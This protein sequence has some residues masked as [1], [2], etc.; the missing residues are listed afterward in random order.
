[1]CLRIAVLL[2]CFLLLPSLAISGPYDPK[3]QWRT[4][5]TEHFAIH[6]YSGEEAIAERLVNI[7]EEA[8]RILSE[9]FDARPWGRTEV[10]VVDQQ[11]AA[12]AFA[13]PIPY[14][15]IIL[16]VVSPLP[17]SNLAD[18]DDWLR[19]VFFHEYTH[20]IHITDT[21]YPAKAFKLLF[22][23]LVAPNGLSP[24]WVTEGIAAYFE[25]VQTSRGRGRSSFTEML[26]RTDILRGKF[27]KLDQMA[28]SQYSWPS[29]MAQYLYGVGFWKFL[30]ESYG[31]ERLMEFSHRYGRSLWFFSLNNKAKKTFGKSFHGLW[32]DWK[33]ALEERYAPLKNRLASEGLKEGEDWLQPNNGESFS[34]PVYADGGRRLYYVA[35]SIHHF[36]ELRSRDI[37]T[38]EE[39]ILFK[40]KEPAQLTVA[41][42][43]KR[44]VF[45]RVGTHRRY[46][47]VSDL[48][49]FDLEKKKEKKLTKGKRA[50]DPDF[51]P[52]GKRIVCVVQENGYSHLAIYDREKKELENL[53]KKEVPPGTEFNNPRWSPDGRW[54]AVSVH[55]KGERNLWLV[56]ARSGHRKRV[57]SGPDLETRPAWHRSSVYFS[58]DRD[59]IPNLYRYDLGSGQTARVTRVLT[60][61]FAPAVSPTGELAFQSYPGPGYEIRRTPPPA[62]LPIKER[63]ADEG[64]RVRSS[65]AES[66]GP[67][68]TT[69]SASKP[70]SP[71]PKVLVPRYLSPNGALID[72]AIFLSLLTTNF[73]PLERHFW[74]A[75]ATFRSD[76]RFVGYDFEYAYQRFRPSYFVGNSFYSVN[77][78]DL[79]GFGNSFFEQ[80][81][82]GYGGIAWPA[83][84]HRFSTS[85]FLEDRSVESGLLAGVTLAT[86]G[87]Y[88]GIYSQYRYA[89]TE[90]TTAA[91][92]IEKGF[93]LTL[94]SE[95]TDQLFGSSANLEQEVFWADARNYVPLGGHHVLA[96]RA[97]GG[98]AFGDQLIQ[99]NFGLGGSIGEG[100]FTG[101]STRVFTLRGLPLITF[102]RDRIWV[103]SA[104]YRF[105][106][107]YLERGAGTLPGAANAAHFALF[108]DFGDA[109]LRENAALGINP[110]YD[111]PLLGVGAEL[112]GEFVI[113][114]Y[115]PV[116][117]RLGYGIIVTNRGRI[118]GLTD[119]LIGQDARNGVLILEVGTSF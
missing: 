9:K 38:G 30:A 59:G 87:N 55:E 10:V 19:E 15:M 13:M 39:R 16:R 100:P 34:Q 5:K 52:D 103:A 71:F 26:L 79:F 119:P 85:Y 91:I 86:L 7:T 75:D 28:G 43:G 2:G 83:G 82:R 23:K 78:G 4:V 114:Y 80:R 76:N 60:G 56:D 90:Q 110:R 107:F 73:D 116:T 118:A 33:Q 77:F 95:V 74:L 99:G 97:G 112:R 81:M 36:S 17:D 102:S 68:P 24:G 22:G 67:S 98:A 35:S 92:S 96:F 65:F 93:R 44:L 101:T 40:K 94:N 32:Q 45:S 53:G 117:G 37:A 14:N 62:P 70:Y 51:S 46:Y 47:Q 21:R 49:E 64:G 54:I 72:N 42:D 12:N 1:M 48:Y 29:W 3:H 115:L 88:S 84:K 31:E 108:A 105:P 25:T 18:Y 106:L 111:R 8:Y 63:V 41:P 6:Y 69:V 61:A 27:L 20:I 66:A 50:R 89:T 58:S 109:Y 11:D 104:E 113:G 57:S